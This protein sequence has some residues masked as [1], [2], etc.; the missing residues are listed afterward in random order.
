MNTADIS[1]WPS[2]EWLRIP[3]IL[4]A[5]LDKGPRSTDQW[6]QAIL[7]VKTFKLIPRPLDK[8]PKP[9][10]GKLRLNLHGTCFG[11]KINWLGPKKHCWKESSWFEEPRIRLGTKVESNSRIQFASNQSKLVLRKLD[12]QPSSKVGLNHDLH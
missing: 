1:F 12:P 7:L 10:S 5:T 9:K 2:L 3:Y 11:V 8:G 6:I 4:R